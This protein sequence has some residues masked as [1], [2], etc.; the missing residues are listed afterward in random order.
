MLLVGLIIWSH[1]DLMFTM[2]SL[3]SALGTYQL[4]SQFIMLVCVCLCIVVLSDMVGIY[5]IGHVI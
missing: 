1:T 3:Q 5:L 2:R 4:Y